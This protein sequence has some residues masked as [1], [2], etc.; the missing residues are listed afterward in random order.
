VRVGDKA[1]VAAAVG[2]TES[3]ES[4]AVPVALVGGEEAL[5]AQPQLPAAAQLL[6]LGGERRRAAIAR[7]GLRGTLV[8]ELDE[9]GSREKRCEIA[10]QEAPVGSDPSSSVCAACVLTNST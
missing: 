6:D 3:L 8:V 10:R 7:G 1:V 2:G 5:A 4:A 9:E